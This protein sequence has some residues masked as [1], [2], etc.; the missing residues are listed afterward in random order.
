MTRRDPIEREMPKSRSS[1]K[2]ATKRPAAS[3]ADSRRGTLREKADALYRAALE[4]CRQRERYA[5]TV[6]GDVD[7]GE[8]DAVSRIV[9]LCDQHLRAA[10][11]NYERASSEASSAGVARNNGRPAR[12]AAATGA[13]GRPAP[14]A[15]PDDDEWWHKANALWHAS[16]EWVRRQQMCDDSSRRL[17]RHTPEKLAELA[18][19][20]DLEASALLALRHA[21]DAYR[22]IRPDAELNGQRSRQQH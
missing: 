20:Y 1:N 19:E 6:N 2:P 17:A 14:P 15:A 4:C 9:C 11:E 10:I 21:V 22:K 7:E 18:L 13:D 16:R 12:P 5:R 8:Q 3:A